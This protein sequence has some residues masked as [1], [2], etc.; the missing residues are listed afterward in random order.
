MFSMKR[1]RVPTQLER[2]NDEPTCA[3]NH[4]TT[5][6][7]ISVVR[8]PPELRPPDHTP[9]SIR[10]ATDQREL[11]APSTS[12]VVDPSAAAFFVTIDVAAAFSVQF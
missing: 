4:S 12:A 3:H 8:S 10:G 9:I 6:T 2:R 1:Q 7:I 11:T 5:L